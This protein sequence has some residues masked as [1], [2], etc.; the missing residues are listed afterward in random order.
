MA[1]IATFGAINLDDNLVN[2]KK[3]QQILTVTQKNPNKVTLQS[4]YPDE[5]DFSLS[6][7]EFDDLGY[8]FYSEGFSV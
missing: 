6:R 8:E 2:P 4:I 1:R 7:E 5:K 3:P